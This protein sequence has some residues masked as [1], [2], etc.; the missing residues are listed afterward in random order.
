MRPGETPDMPPKDPKE[1]GNG[2]ANG[3][4]GPKPKED[5]HKDLPTDTI[6]L[7]QMQT[8]QNMK[9]MEEMLAQMAQLVAERPKR[10]GPGEPDS[11]SDT[12]YFGAPKKDPTKKRQEKAMK[13]IHPPIFKRD[14][15]ERPEAHLLRTVDWYDAIGVTTNLE[16]IYSF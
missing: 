7:L 14:P 13:R 2:G 4:N 3:G 5:E 12:D 6:E 16:K 1:N 10:E 11:D 15:G 8:H 9:A